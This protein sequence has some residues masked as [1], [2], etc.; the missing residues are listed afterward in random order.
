MQENRGFLK[1]ILLEIM[2]N[3]GI[4]LAIMPEW[5]DIYIQIKV[6]LFIICYILQSIFFLFNKTLPNAA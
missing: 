3:A 5:I 1:K 2:K 6:S 4:F